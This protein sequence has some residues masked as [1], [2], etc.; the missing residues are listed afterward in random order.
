[1][2]KYALKRVKVLTVNIFRRE[3]TGDIYQPLST[4]VNIL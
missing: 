1:M 3:F 4:I 2:Y